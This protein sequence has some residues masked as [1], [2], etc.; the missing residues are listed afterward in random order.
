MVQVQRLAHDD[1]NERDLFLLEVD[2]D[3]LDEVPDILGFSS[4]HFACLLAL[5][6]PTFS[7]AQVHRLAAKLLGNGAAYVCAWG[8]GCERVHDLIDD[9]ILIFESDPT[10]D[11]VILTTWHDNES[12]EEALFYLLRTTWPAADYFDTCRA[13]LVIVSDSARWVEICRSGLRNPREL[14]ARV[15]APTPEGAV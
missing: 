11:N 8:P 5:D 2:A 7:D 12:L 4:P 13:A 15:S 1:V 9:A 14:V 3:T 6:G 10:E